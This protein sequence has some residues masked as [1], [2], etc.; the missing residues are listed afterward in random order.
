MSLIEIPSLREPEERRKRPATPYAKKTGNKEKLEIYEE[1]HTQTFPRRNLNKELREKVYAQQRQE[2]RYLTNRE[3]VE[4]REE[5]RQQRAYDKQPNWEPTVETLADLVEKYD[6]LSVQEQ[7]PEGSVEYNDDD[8]TQHLQEVEERAKKAMHLSTVPYA[9]DY[10]NANHST[11]SWTSCY[12]DQCS[13]HYSEKQH[14]GYFPHRKRTCDRFWFDCENDTCAE[15]LFDKRTAQRF[16]G[17][18]DNDEFSLR[19]NLVVNYCCTMDT[20]H[21]CLNNECQR[22]ADNKHTF[23]FDNQSFLGKRLAPGIPPGTL[24]L[25]TPQN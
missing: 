16:P 24:Q 13:T 8:V 5:L 20:W 25:P 21:H 4:K 6:Q 7:S 19:M 1:L 14:T 3:I 22:H 17:K 12:K 11:L 10:R 23:G 2:Q 9:L 15:H 18:H